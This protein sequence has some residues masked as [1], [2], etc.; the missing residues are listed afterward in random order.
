MSRT[1][2][3]KLLTAPDI[4]TLARQIRERIQG[5]GTPPLA[6][7]WRFTDAVERAATS[8]REE[9]L[10]ARFTG[11]VVELLDRLARRPDADL[12][13]DGWP[14]EW[15]AGLFL[16]ARR[17]VWVSDDEMESVRRSLVSLLYHVQEKRTW[18]VGRDTAPGLGSPVLE[19]HRTAFWARLDFRH[20]D[21]ALQVSAERLLART[22]DEADWELGALLGIQ[23]AHGDAEARRAFRLL[24]R[25]GSEARRDR[26][27]FTMD[28]EYARWSGSAERLIYPLLAT[29]GGHGSTVREAD[30][31][32]S[33]EQRW[34]AKAA[35]RLGTPKQ[36]E[37]VIIGQL[38]KPAVVQVR[39]ARP[40]FADRLLQVAS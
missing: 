14:G 36:A 26:A 28:R 3:E 19:L 16:V 33:E 18:P 35:G 37:Q 17:T 24:R 20:H 32:T 1:I 2:T 7:D 38:T 25:L 29:I 39:T 31:P 34:A 10:R 40:S 12:G 8:S 15:P 11:A 30:P 21:N 6:E 4:E 13:K 27:L 5:G 22:E 23:A 9:P